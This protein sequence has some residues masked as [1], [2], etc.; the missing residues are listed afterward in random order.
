M[1]VYMSPNRQR[2]RLLVVTVLA[3]VI[4]ATVGLVAGRTTATSADDEVDASRLRGRRV[5]AALRALPV[6]YGELRS[7][8]GESSQLAFDDAVHRII[9]QATTALDGAPWLGPSANDR[10]VRDVEAVQAALEA[11]ASPDEFAAAVEKAAA[12]VE[13]VFDTPSGTG[14]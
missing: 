3:L 14:A 11:K 4:G 10:V 7:G 5:A 13:D 1:A 8:S 9:G 12:T 2:R 6:E